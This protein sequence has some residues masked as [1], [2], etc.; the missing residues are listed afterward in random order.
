V[1]FLVLASICGS[2][3]RGNWQRKMMANGETSP[4]RGKRGKNNS[5]PPIWEWFTTP[6]Y[7]DFGGCF[8][9][10]FYPHYP[11]SQ[12]AKSHPQN[13]EDTLNE[14]MVFCWEFPYWDHRMRLFNIKGMGR[15]LVNSP[16]F[17]G[18]TILACKIAISAVRVA[19]VVG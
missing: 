18:R 19:A 10:F 7:G 3:K 12:F 6:I 15:I 4:K 17:A 1:E 13:I 2:V 11:G 16:H 8:M 5:K 9:A 14:T